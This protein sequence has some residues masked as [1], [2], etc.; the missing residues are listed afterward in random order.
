VIR[1]MI[2]WLGD[3]ACSQDFDAQMEREGRAEDEARLE[4]MRRIQAANDAISM[5]RAGLL[6]VRAELEEAAV[7]TVAEHRRTLPC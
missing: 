4:Q 5:T 6:A 2:K 3:Q 1:R 7:P